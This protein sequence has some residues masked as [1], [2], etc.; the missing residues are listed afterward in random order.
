MPIYATAAELAA[1]VDPDATEP[2]PV[3]KATVL[4]R[5]A[6]QLV[7]DATANAR[8]TT[9]AATGLPTLHR[10]REAMREATLEQASAWVAAGLDPSLGVA[11]L[12]RTVAS[13]S[14]GSVSVSY[15]QDAAT[16]AERRALAAGD[17]LTSAARSILAAAGLISSA[18]NVTAGTETFPVRVDPYNPLTGALL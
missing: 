2:T 14:Q 5:R 13:K 3:P 9:N 8:Y 16:D 18:L 10:V 6:S 11:Q 12:P 17:S 1:Y 7:L 15:Q 4:L